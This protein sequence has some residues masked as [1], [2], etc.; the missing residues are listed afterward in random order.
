MHTCTCIVLPLLKTQPKASI[1]PPH[2]DTEQMLP[3]YAATIH[4][5]EMAVHGMALRKL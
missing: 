5:Q 3:L 4:K 1:P 2:A